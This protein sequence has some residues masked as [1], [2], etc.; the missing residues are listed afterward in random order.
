MFGTDR[1]SVQ[2]TAPCDAFALEPPPPVSR[3]APAKA[4]GYATRRLELALLAS[5]GGKPFLS[6]KLAEGTS[7]VF[8]GTESRG[9]FV[10]LESRFDI[11]IDGWAA[12]KDLEPIRPGEMLGQGTPPVVSMTGAKLALQDAPAPRRVK[13]ESPLRLGY[14]ATSK[15]IGVAEEG[16]SVFVMSEFKGHANVLPVDLY[17]S[18]TEDGGFWM[19]LEDLEP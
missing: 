10:H 12:L 11:A 9:G 14:E 15:Q 8:W 17:V 1:Q 18:P 16:A 2:F 4:R 13:T 6:M 7:Q 3:A 5:P 19:R